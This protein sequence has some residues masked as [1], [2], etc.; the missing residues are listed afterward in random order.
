MNER[1]CEQ[2][3]HYAAMLEE[4]RDLLAARLPVPE[5]DQYSEELSLADAEN[6]S[7]RQECKRRSLLLL[8][9]AKAAGVWIFDDT[10]SPEI[11]ETFPT[12]IRAE[13]ERLRKENADL[14][15]RLDRAA[16]R[17][18]DGIAMFDKLLAEE[19]A[20]VA[21]LQHSVN[22][23]AALKQPQDK[24]GRWVLF[25]RSDHVLR[26]LDR[27]NWHQLA[28]ECLDPWSTYEAAKDIQQRGFAKLDIINLDDHKETP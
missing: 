26:Y 22:E 4:I 10:I 13:V 17:E 20:K 1:Q 27:R 11:E 5:D 19:R 18:S 9:A 8:D 14:H 7:L 2:V 28:S 24:P 21:N 15:D 16:Q 6:N 3:V 25:D 23:L 12:Q